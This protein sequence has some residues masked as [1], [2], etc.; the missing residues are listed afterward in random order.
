MLIRRSQIDRVYV[1]KSNLDVSQVTTG[2][3]RQGHTQHN[4]DV[5]IDRSPNPMEDSPLNSSGVIDRQKLLLSNS[6][7]RMLH[8][9][10]SQP[11][12]SQLSISHC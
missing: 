12:V 10:L 6:G 4:T 2:I 8:Y 9:G 3:Q 7:P 5:S 11:I 1:S